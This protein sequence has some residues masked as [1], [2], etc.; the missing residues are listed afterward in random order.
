[1]LILAIV[2]IIVAV[3]A[4]TMATTFFIEGSPELGIVMGVLTAIVLLAGISLLVHTVKDDTTLQVKTEVLNHLTYTESVTLTPKDNEFFYQ[5]NDSTMVELYE[6][7]T[8]D[9]YKKKD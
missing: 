8:T 6:Y 3:A 4:T 9:P 1:M 2:T 5:L 7:L